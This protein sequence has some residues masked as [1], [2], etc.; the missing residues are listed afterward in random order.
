[1]SP[2]TPKGAPAGAPRITAQQTGEAAT[3]DGNAADEL[4]PTIRAYVDSLDLPPW[5]PAPRVE[6]RRLRHGLAALLV[7][8]PGAVTR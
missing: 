7:L 5:Q 4:Q 8:K 2:K 6:A 1:M 3:H